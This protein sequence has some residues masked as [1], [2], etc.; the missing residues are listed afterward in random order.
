MMILR[1]TYT[2]NFSP[3]TYKHIL[4]YFFSFYR[5]HQYNAVFKLLQY[6]ISR[7]WV[8]EDWCDSLQYVFLNHWVGMPCQLQRRFHMLGVYL[9]WG[10]HGLFFESSQDGH[11]CNT[12]WLMP[13][14]RE[15]M[16]TMYVLNSININEH[17]SCFFK[18][19]N[20]FFSFISVYQ[21]LN[22]SFFMN[23]FWI[24]KLC[25][26]AWWSTNYLSDLFMF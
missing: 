7:S 13:F 15:D 1:V 16:P 20:T 26:T 18:H 3:N 24:S 25:K 19:W 8:L 10:Q 4:Q 9:S 14:L 21:R 11:W 22:L 2:I 5:W 12:L 6:I 17:I 23:C